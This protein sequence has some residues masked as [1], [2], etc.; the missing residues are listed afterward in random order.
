MTEKQVKKPEEDVKPDKMAVVPVLT[1]ATALAKAQQFM[2]ELVPLF[3]REKLQPPKDLPEFLA[4]IAEKKIPPS[5]ALDDKTFVDYRAQRT[6]DMMPIGSDME[7]AGESDVLKYYGM[8]NKATDW[9]NKKGKLDFNQEA[10][11]ADL[12]RLLTPLKDGILA[13]VKTLYEQKAKTYD[14]DMRRTGESTVPE[15]KYT[16]ASVKSLPEE[17][18]D[19]IP[20]F[21]KKINT[22]FK[23]QGLNIVASYDSRTAVVTMIMRFDKKKPNT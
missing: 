6:P 10:A 16:L 23:E 17:V 12:T 18:R 4:Y 15:I 11:L 1:P 13:G 21:I 3:T 2:K 20:E 9:L 22:E 19:M 5:K 7:S 14:D 8:L